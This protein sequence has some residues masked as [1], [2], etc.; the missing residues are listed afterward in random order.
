MAT[1]IEHETHEARAESQAEEDTEP[2]SHVTSHRHSHVGEVPTYVC[3]VDR[4]CE[5]GEHE[6]DGDQ[7][8]HA[9]LTCAREP[10]FPFTN[11]KQARSVL[12][13]V[14]VVLVC[15]RHRHGR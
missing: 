12:F 5:Q 7:C 9:R 1:A 3:D 13:L 15:S 2:H 8:P 6:R 14:L 11:G 10:Q 4:P